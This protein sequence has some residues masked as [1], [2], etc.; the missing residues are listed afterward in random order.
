[1]RS[2][3]FSNKTVLHFKKA[4]SVHMIT[5]NRTREKF[6]AKYKEGLSNQENCWNVLPGRPQSRVPPNRQTEPGGPGVLGGTFFLWSL[7][8]PDSLKTLW[9][10]R[11]HLHPKTL[12]LMSTILDRLLR[13]LFFLSSS[14]FCSRISE[15]EHFSK[16]L[17]CLRISNFLRNCKSFE[18]GDL[19]CCTAE[20]RK[21]S[22]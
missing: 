1:M 11:E 3:L 5:E 20:A 22:T 10:H 8:I 7:I 16:P 17:H 2:S 9:I 21:S 12:Y 15:V 13:S 14:F 18:D 4:D 6:L 19:I